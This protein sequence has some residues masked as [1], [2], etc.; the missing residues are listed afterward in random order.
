MLSPL[1]TSEIF[2]TTRGYRIVSDLCR[3]CCLLLVF[4]FF[5]DV[6]GY[7]WTV[8]Q[9]VLLLEFVKKINK[10]Q[11]DIEELELDR[12]TETKTSANTITEGV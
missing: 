5:F 12:K 11:N 6:S 8:L 4:F 10:K 3:C 1:L 9:G 2:E 7:F